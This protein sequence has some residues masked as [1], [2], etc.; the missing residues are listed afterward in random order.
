MSTPKQIRNLT[1]TAGELVQLA[2][3]WPQR[4]GILTFLKEALIA[5]Q[6]FDSA[7]VLRDQEIATKRAA[8]K[9]KLVPAP[10]RT[11]KKLQSRHSHEH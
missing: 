11:L 4:L 1:F 5:R 2:H 10:L 3:T 6:D 8:I 7:A 9:E